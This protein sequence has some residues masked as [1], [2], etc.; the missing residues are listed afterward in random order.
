MLVDVSCGR[1][2][3]LAHHGAPDQGT[4]NLFVAKMDPG[5]PAPAPDPVLYL[6]GDLG[7]A[8]DYTMLG[9]QLEALDRELIV[10]DARGTGHSEPSLVCPDFDVM[11]KPPVASPVDDP[12]TRTEL[13][14]AIGT[15]HDRLISQ[16]V[17]LSAFDLREM[18]ADAEVLREPRWG[19]TDGTSWRLGQRPRN[20]S[21]IPSEYPAHVR[22]AVLDSP[23]WPGVD[24][25]VESVEATRHAIE[26]LIATC[27]ASS[28]CRRSAPHLGAGIRK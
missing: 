2:T 22:A 15:C 26:A 20:R 8:P 14:G 16:D 11:P 7:V 4:V 28:A 1:L 24:P 5:N 27:A 23:E 9:T 6:G 3:V 17:D 19:S 12:R 10:L 18:A 13:L 25:F 21:R